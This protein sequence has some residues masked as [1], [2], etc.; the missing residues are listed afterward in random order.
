LSRLLGR[1][2]DQH[3]VGYTQTVSANRGGVGLSVSTSLEVP[4]VDAN[5]QSTICERNRK[6]KVSLSP[7]EDYSPGVQAL[8]R[9]IALWRS[10][11]FSRALYLVRMKNIN[12]GRGY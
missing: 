7:T 6:K 10:M 3:D 12:D 1:Y 2:K 11:V 5:T 9:K 4:N 8:P